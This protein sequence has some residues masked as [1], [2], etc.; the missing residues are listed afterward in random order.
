MDV[1]NLFAHAPGNI[2][3]YSRGQQV[4]AELGLVRSE[5]LLKQ[6]KIELHRNHIFVII[7]TKEDYVVIP[8]CP[9]RK[10]AYQLFTNIVISGVMY[11]KADGKFFALS[12]D[13]LRYAT[14]EV[15]DAIVFDGSDS[16]KLTLK[17]CFWCRINKPALAQKA[18]I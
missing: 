7:P 17:S 15:L 10:N 13:D 12:G 5:L 14:R 4:F 18:K 16:K 8:L 11:V 3:I 9:S 1:K 2:V 6:T